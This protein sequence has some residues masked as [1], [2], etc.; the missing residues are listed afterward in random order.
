MPVNYKLSKVYKI[1]CYENDNIY[2][3][4]TC[5][6]LSLRKAQH[7]SCYKRFLEGKFRYMTSF[8]IIKHD[9][10]Y[11]E[12]LES[13]EC[14]NKE[15]LLQLEG[16][17]IREMNCINKV[18]PCR[19][20][21]EWREENKEKIKEYRKL[22]LGENKEKIK[23]Y[24][25]LYVEENKEQIKE[26]RKEY[27]NKYYQEK[28][29]EILIKKGEILLCDCGINYTNNHKLRHEKSKKHLLYIEAR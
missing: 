13:K 12:L 21:K 18:I 4:S 19:T 5:S 10:C 20:G 9:N 26:Y 1:C 22:Y 15:E 23:E 8:E 25:K 17:Y 2:I 6:K 14:E 29:E 3:G 24:R 11:I 27:N 16:K 7:Q 28:K